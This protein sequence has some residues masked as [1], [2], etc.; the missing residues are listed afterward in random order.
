MKIAIWGSSGHALVVVDIIRS[1]GEY[2]IV[3][4]LDDLHPEKYGTYVDGIPVLGGI[5]QLQIL[6]RG[7]INNIIF[8]FGHCASRLKLSEF[9]ALNGFELATAIHPKA[10]VAKNASIGPGTVIAAGAVV[11]PLAR[12]GMNCII[13]TLSSVDHECILGDAVHISP[14]THLGGLVTV[15]DGSWIGVGAAVRDHIHI[16]KCSMIGAGAVVVDNIPSGVLAY[17]VPA[18]VMGPYTEARLSI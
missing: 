4:F 17:G 7:G 1:C 11:N 8:G 5:E 9:I 13:N 14:G 10:V 12:I 16:G 2:E 3:G 18:K 15:D 6:K